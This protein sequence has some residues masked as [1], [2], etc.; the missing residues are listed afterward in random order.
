MID[1]KH[2]SLGIFLTPDAEFTLPINNINKYFS[3]LT[4]LPKGTS[5]NDDIP[6]LVVSPLIDGNALS[7]QHYSVG[8]KC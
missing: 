7:Y 8:F 4:S 1:A 2:V 5:T 6:L 3:Y